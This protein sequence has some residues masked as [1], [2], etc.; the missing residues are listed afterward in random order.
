MVCN[1]TLM[2]GLGLLAL[3][4]PALS[5]RGQYD[6]RSDRAE[7][8]GSYDRDDRD[9][10]SGQYGPDDRDR[11]SDRNDDRRGDRRGGSY[12]RLPGG[13]WA[14]SCRKADVGGGMLRAQCQD[15]RGKWRE[16]QLSL[17]QCQSGRAGNQFGR[18]VCE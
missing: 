4:S 18:L 15:Q 12:D 16:S 9:N 6:D 8:S 14:Q 11:R 2:I 1:R 5:Q 13:S 7:R 3:A 10:R 17:R